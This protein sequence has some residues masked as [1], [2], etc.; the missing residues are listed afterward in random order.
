MA[1]QRAVQTAIIISIFAALGTFFVALRLWTRLVIIRAPGWEDWVIVASWLCAT[2]TVITIGLQIKFGLGEHGANLSQ[3][4]VHNLLLNIYISISTYC[5]SI[6]LTKTA[7]LMQ[8]QRVFATRK[9]QIWCWSFITIIVGYTIATVL[10]CIFVCTPIPRFW[11]GQPGYCINELASWFANAAINIVTDLMIVILPIPVIKNLNLPK[12]QKRLLMGVFA[13]GV[14][15][16][17]ISIVRLHSLLV[18]TT[19]KDQ[20]YDNAP[21]ATFSIVE[22]NVAIIGACLPTLRPLLAKW[23]SGLS[24]TAGSRGS[25]NNQYAQARK[26]S[27]VLGIGM[28]LNSLSSS[29]RGVQRLDDWGEGDDKIRV[30]TNIDVKV[31][32]KDGTIDGRED[33]TE[34]LFRNSGHTV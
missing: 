19:S 9:F 28:P 7:I 15:V 3:S 8:Y 25:K 31:K 23:I 6:G 2:A 27:S 13:F 5:A 18:I 21:V 24:T 30:V 4:D 14:V 20:S 22:V 16:C 12:K 33:S 1:G 26:R 29:Q 10:A 32:D 11:T 17:I 34:S